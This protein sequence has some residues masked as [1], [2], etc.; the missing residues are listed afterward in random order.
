[1]DTDDVIRSLA[2]SVR[3]VR[4]LR[5]PWVRTFVWASVAVAYLA[6]LVLFSSPR[7]DLGD[8]M[9]DPRFLFEQGAALLTGV[10]AAAAALAT[11]I[12]GYSRRVMLLPVAPM[13]AWVGTVAAGA[14]QEYARD[15]AGVLAGP[16]GWACLGAVLSGAAV[17]AVIM[18]T[19]LRRGAPVTPHLSAALGAL[20]AAG[21][22]NVGVCIFHPHS[23]NLVMLVWHCGAVLALTAL[24]G[25]AGG[26]L[27]QWPGRGISRLFGGA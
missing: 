18:G 7:A 22:G 24:A 4:T 13:A 2:A 21:L 12:P 9:G 23:S 25:V 19:L 6:V 20:A 16:F 1:M 14:A 11:A 10:G 3:P 5:P 8:R 17:P 27:L 15:G 26:R